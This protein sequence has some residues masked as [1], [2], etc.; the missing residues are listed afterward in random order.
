M[1]KI[2]GFLVLEVEGSLVCSM[3]CLGEFGPF[4]VGLVF[5]GFFAF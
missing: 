1:E 5:V 4:G 2:N 3:R